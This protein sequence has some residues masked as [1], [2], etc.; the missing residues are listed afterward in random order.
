MGK[1]SRVLTFFNT[2]RDADCSFCVYNIRKSGQDFC[3]ARRPMGNPDCRRF[4]YDPLKRAPRN[5]PPLREYDPD[6]FKL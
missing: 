5:L 3:S 4:R 2:A 1:F 6:E